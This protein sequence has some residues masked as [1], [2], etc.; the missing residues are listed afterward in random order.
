MKDL[1]FGPFPVPILGMLTRLVRF[2]Q[3]LH[4]E[5]KEENEEKESNKNPNCLSKNWARARENVIR[6]EADQISF[7]KYS[8]RIH[9]RLH[10]LHTALLNH[11][12]NCRIKLNLLILFGQPNNCCYE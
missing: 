6:F 9:Q 1:F 11:H 5:R 3:I 2:P 10:K 12:R 8:A 4:L 7:D